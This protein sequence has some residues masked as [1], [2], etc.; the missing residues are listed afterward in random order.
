MSDQSQPKDYLDVLDGVRG[1]M[2]L[3]VLYGHLLMAVTGTLPRWGSPAYAVDVFMFLSGFLMMYHWRLRQG[4][5]ASLRSQALDFYVRRFFRIAPLYYVLLLIALLFQDYFLQQR[6]FIEVTVQPPWAN[7]QTEFTGPTDRSITLS[8]ILAHLTFVFGFIP[9]F[10]S[11]NMLPDW[12]IG[13]E[14]QFYMFMPFMALILAR[15]G[16]FSM[17]IGSLL[18]VY[19]C[20]R[21]FG[22]YLKPGP[23]GNFPQPT[24]IFFKLNVFVAGLCFAE[25]YLCRK[26]L[27]TLTWF[28]AGMISLIGIGTPAV[29]CILMLI[30]LLFL[31]DGKRKVELIHRVL[32]G[33][34]ARFFGDTSYC[35][36]LLHMLFLYPTVYF[37]LHQSWFLN[38]GNAG[39]VAVGMVLIGVPVYV[40]SYL[41][42]LS[43]ERSSIEMG[44]NFLR[45]LRGGGG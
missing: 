17:M 36:Y 20:E 34:V 11:N 28:A 14:M 7:Q 38:L 42:H 21:L 29:V 44:R 4:N 13:L 31:D 39:R 30:S 32:A 45:A 16:P 8:S 19:A 10:A 6:H 41:L 40:F 2:A 24:L 9:K 26:Q 27:S 3:W 35:S 23:L 33:R 18:I 25:A 5:F 1:L 15:S 22:L 43:V 12:S 37:L